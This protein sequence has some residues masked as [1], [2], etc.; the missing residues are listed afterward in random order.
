MNQLPRRAFLRSAATLAATA[1]LA[2]QLIPLARAADSC[3]DPAS[4]ALRV[5][6]NY[7]SKAADTAQSCVTC[8]F[9]AAEEAK[10]DCG[11]CQIMSGPVDATG[12][13]DSWSPKA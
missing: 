9:F 6:M 11:D 5:S 1:A 12:H 13:C 4:E 7:V 2:P 3:T 10:P 8:G